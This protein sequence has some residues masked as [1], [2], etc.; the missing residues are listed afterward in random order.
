MTS[1]VTGRLSDLIADDEAADPFAP[2][3]RSLLGHPGLLLSLGLIGIALTTLIFVSASLWRLELQPPNRGADGLDAVLAQ[4]QVDALRLHEAAENYAENPL[5]EA[6]FEDRFL[7]LLNRLAQLETGP[8]RHFV[9]TLGLNDDVAAARRDLERHEPAAAGRDP[10][11]LAALT[12]RLVQLDETLALEGNRA[13][14]AR[15]AVLS[16][17]AGAIRGLRPLAALAGLAGLLGLALLT[18]RMLRAERGAED[19]R[20]LERDLRRARDAAAYM[21]NIGAVI[22]HQMRTPLA[23]I[24]STA[25]RMLARPAPADQ[26][27]VAAAMLR[28]RRQVGRLLHFMDQAVL[29]GA[30]ETRIPEVELRPV[31]A[32]DLIAMIMAHEGLQDRRDRLVLPPPGSAPVRALCDRELAFHALANLIENA[33]KYSPHHSPVELHAAQ[34]D[35]MAVIS[36]TDHGGGVPAAEQAAIFQRFRRGS[37]AGDRPG[38]G[39]GL[40]LARRLAEVQGGTVRVVSDGRTGARFDLCLPAAGSRSGAL[41]REAPALSHHAAPPI[42]AEAHHGA[43]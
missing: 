41:D 12:S 6:E 17:R 27:E 19:R 39:I 36:V 28:V 40:W 38:T 4:V 3:R 10:A 25:Q 30:V 24:D 13:S 33:L 8:Q 9:R 16:D 31:P 5:N 15:R 23:V 14:L 11:A 18:V 20:R 32:D 7:L 35:G 29:A 42:G 26:A 2:G 43:P 1:G 34:I 37:T 22:S 21:R